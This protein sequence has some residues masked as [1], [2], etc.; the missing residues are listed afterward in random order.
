[1]L[2][3]ISNDGCVYLVSSLWKSCRVESDYVVFSI[4]WRYPCLLFVRTRAKSF[5]VFQC[6]LEKPMLTDRVMNLLSRVS[7]AWITHAY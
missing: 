7:L 4:A 3:E 1:M 6:S 2:T 5:C